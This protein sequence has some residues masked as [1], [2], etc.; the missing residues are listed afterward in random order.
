MDSGVV[1]FHHPGAG[2]VVCTVSVPDLTGLMSML[3]RSLVIS[4][5]PISAVPE[6][7]AVVD[8]SEDPQA[9]IAAEMASALT[10]PT[11]R[12][13]SMEVSFRRESQDGQRG[14]RA[15]WSSAT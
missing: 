4:Q 5:L 14:L 8:E 2:S 10:R 7:L 6:E 11:V 13:S 12:L 1:P 3:P 9:L 15:A